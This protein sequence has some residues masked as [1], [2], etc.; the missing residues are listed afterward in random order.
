MKIYVCFCEDGSSTY[1]AMATQDKNQADKFVKEHK[2]ESFY[3]TF[4]NGCYYDSERK[5]I[6]ESY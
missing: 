6:K 3:K 1:I 5:V 4:I 2:G